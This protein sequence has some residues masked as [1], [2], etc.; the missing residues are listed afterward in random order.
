MCMYS[1]MLVH[2]S[3]PS[4]KCLSSQVK[5]STYSSAMWHTQC[6]DVI[7]IEVPIIAPD[8]IAYTEL[9]FEDNLYFSRLFFTER[10]RT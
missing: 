10:I 5:L 7:L 9:H 3:P 4:E 1:F 6:D 8:M 2:I